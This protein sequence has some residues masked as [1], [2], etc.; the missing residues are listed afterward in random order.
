[1][2]DRSHRLVEL[3]PAS[4]WPGWPWWAV[5]VCGV[6]IALAGTA[7]ILQQQLNDDMPLCPLKLA[8]DYP[9]PTCGLS[10]GVLAI[11][12]GDILAAWLYNPLV[13]TMLGYGIVLA[14]LRL[15]FARRV[16]WNLSP[17]QRRW[18]WAIL[19]AAI[20]ADWVYLVAAG[21]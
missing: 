12:R 7:V 20:L 2:P 4:R 15:G 11:A 5:V 21:V 19:I 1:M 18:A 9:C 17:R 10:R 14:V 3:V 6:W 16:R 8:T 13:F